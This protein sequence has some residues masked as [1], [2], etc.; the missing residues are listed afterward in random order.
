MTTLVSRDIDTIINSYRTHDELKEYYQD[1]DYN[2]QRY[3]KE[4]MASE[5]DTDDTLKAFPDQTNGFN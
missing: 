1:T 2:W 5:W 3:V 4:Y